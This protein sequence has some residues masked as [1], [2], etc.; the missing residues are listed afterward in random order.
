[1]KSPCEILG[2]PLH[3]YTMQEILEAISARLSDRE[4]TFIVTANA[5][6]IMMCQKDT[7]Y[8]DIVAS[9]ADIVLPDGAGAVWAGRYLGW[10]VPERVAGFDLYC[11][12]LEF[13]ATHGYKSFFFGG[14][15]GIAE[16]A[17]AK[18]ES[19]YPGIQIV[20]CRNGYFSAEEEKDILDD[21]NASGAEMLFVA[22]GAPKQERW[23]AANLENLRPTLLMGI[24]GSFDVLAGKVERAPK[25][26][27]D[28]SLEWAFRLYKQ[29]QRFMR[30]MALPKFV[31]KVLLSKH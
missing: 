13:S 16:A 11:K 27:Q 19:L 26:M 1:M 20:G 23:L 21:I 3:P 31:F 2:V 18:A 6:I 30:M 15:E 8:K 29:P 5:E 4:R 22:L 24:G 17:R 10:D 9:K 14:G 25:W 28:A 7:E 12:L